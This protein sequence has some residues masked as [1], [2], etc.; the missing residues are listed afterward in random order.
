MLRGFI[1]RRDAA[2][3]AERQLVDLEAQ[4]V[5]DE[6]AVDIGAQIAHDAIADGHAAGDGLAG[7]LQSLLDQGVEPLQR[8]VRGTRLGKALAQPRVQFAQLAKR[9]Q[10][11]PQE[12]LLA[13]DDEAALAGLDVD[14]QGLQPL[15]VSLGAQGLAAFAVAQQQRG[16][17]LRSADGRTDEGQEGRHQQTQR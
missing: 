2:L 6:L 8:A 4:L 16:Q 9:L 7:L 5:H 10:V 17:A 13:S 1:G 3:L 15:Q 11:G 14:E 12:G